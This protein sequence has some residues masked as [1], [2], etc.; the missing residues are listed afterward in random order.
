MDGGPAYLVAVPYHSRPD[1]L[2]EALASVVT[3]DDPDWECV[4]VDD[5]PTGDDV[6]AVVEALGDARISTVRNPGTLGVAASFNRCFDVA[7]ER[8]ATL[9]MVLHADDLLEPTYLSTIKAAH[10]RRPE[11]VCVAPRVGVIGAD[12]RA[13]RTVPDTVKALL[14]PRGVDALAGERGLAILLRGQFFH[15]PSVSYR[16]GLLHGHVWNARWQQV[17]DLELYAR[18]LLDGATIALEPRRLFRYRRHEGSMT[19]INSGTLVRSV[20]ETEL[21]RELAR[22]AAA[23]GWRRAAMAGRVRLAVRAQALL[24]AVTLLVRGRARDALRAGRL[25]LAP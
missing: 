20:E 14:R 21:C 10:A 1:L 4:V 24:R 8:D 23:R 2:R 19:Q 18:L 5:S 6:G 22:E 13:R 25:A 17:M 9:A 3:Q 15:C 12:G 7:R 16:V 11:A